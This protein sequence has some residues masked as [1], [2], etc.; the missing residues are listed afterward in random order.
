MSLLNSL[1]EG[2][3]MT[4]KERELARRRQAREEVGES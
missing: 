4:E 2:S 1:R 3:T